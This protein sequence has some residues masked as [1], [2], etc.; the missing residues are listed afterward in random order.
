[1]FA[2]S[3]DISADLVQNSLPD[4]VS[5]E[6]RIL[7]CFCSI[8][9]IFPFGITSTS[10]QRLLSS[11]CMSPISVPGRDPGL[12]I[13]MCCLIADQDA[14]NAGLINSGDVYA[15]LTGSN[16]MVN[17]LPFLASYLAPWN[18]FV[19]HMLLI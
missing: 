11:V 5:G 12:C 10:A 3:Q 2:L 19:P 16:V 9:Y 6:Y 15:V 18:V 13:S 7:F 17:T 1:M 8:L 14:K 4:M